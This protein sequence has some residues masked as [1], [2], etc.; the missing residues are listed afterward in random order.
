MQHEQRLAEPC[1]P[2][3]HG[4]HPHVVDEALRHRERPPAK[5]DRRLAELLHLGELGAELAQH[6][7]R[8]GRR[9]DHRDRPRLRHVGGGGQHGGAAQ[10]VADQQRR[11]I[12]RLGHGGGGGGHVGHVAAE[13][14]PP[15]LALAAAEA[16]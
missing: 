5:G 2:L 12:A 1:D 11:R 9:A 13:A 10:A 16:R 6:V 14:R 3:T 15:E 4:L 7:A 8:I